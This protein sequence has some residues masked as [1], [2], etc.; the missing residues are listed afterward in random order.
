[1][2]DDDN[3]DGQSGNGQSNNNRQGH[4]RNKKN[5]LD[6]DKPTPEELEIDNYWHKWMS[7]LRVLDYR[8]KVI[9]YRGNARK[10]KRHIV[11]DSMVTAISWEDA[12]V[13]KASISVQ[14]AFKGMPIKEG[15]QVTVFYAPKNV[16]KWTK[17]WTLRVDEVSVDAKA[18]TLEIQASDELAWL[19]KSKDDFTYKKGKGKSRFKRPHGWRGHWIVR[20]ICKRYGIRIGSIVKCRKLI[21]NFDEKNSTPLA[22]IEKVYDLERKETGRKYV[23]QMRHGKLY[24]TRLRRSK[25]LLIYGGTALEATITRRVSK[26][27]A[28][29]LEVTGRLKGEDGE[30][31]ND[32]DEDR[33]GNAN[34]DDENNRG[35]AKKKQEFTLTAGKKVRRRFGHIHQF[36]HLEDEERT[37]RALHREARKEMRD[38]N[39]PEREV[40]M[41][42]PGYPGLR[43]GDA[44]RVAF[45][46][47]GFVELM[48]VTAASHS[49]SGGD[50]TTQLTLSLDEFYLDKEGDAIREKICKKARKHDRKAPWFCSDKVDLFSPYR[51]RKP[52][53][54]N[55][56]ERGIARAG[57]GTRPTVSAGFSDKGIEDRGA[58][59][60]GSVFK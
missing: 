41:T 34:N 18:M 35:D 15:H 28:T 13:Q 46:R 2:A 48:Y 9:A 17:L 60:A 42:V 50:Y 37:I 51:R 10:G 14:A 4:G 58:A 31:S 43:R 49:A 16:G 56:G 53:H 21:K 19:K 26:K 44:V 40:E 8:W 3:G 32:D 29:R 24:I 11:L 1:M 30:D 45:P 7:P 23:I 38:N 27:L 36:L 59:G 25:D 57:L 6:V 33:Q 22:A 20:D 5:K 54:R 47:E 12:L 52:K 55:K 39:E